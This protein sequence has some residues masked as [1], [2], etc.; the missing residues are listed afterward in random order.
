MRA[1][2]YWTGCGWK[3]SLLLNPIQ[4]FCLYFT[5]F[6]ISIFFF[7]LWLLHI[8]LIKKKI[9]EKIYIYTSK[10]IKFKHAGTIARPLCSLFNLTHSCLQ[11]TKGLWV[12]TGKNGLSIWRR[13]TSWSLQEHLLPRCYRHLDFLCQDVRLHWTEKSWIFKVIVFSLICFVHLA[14]LLPFVHTSCVTP[15]SLFYVLG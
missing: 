11:R 14:L 8:K 9:S 10:G 6:D 2:Q 13:C 5:H 1:H 12:I 4:I 7:L 15:I 3:P